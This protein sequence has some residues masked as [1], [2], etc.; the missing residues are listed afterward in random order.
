MA[1]R[2]S[3]AGDDF[4]RLQVVSG[5]DPGQLRVVLAFQVLRY[6]EVPGAPGLPAEPAQGDIADQ[7]LEE[8]ILASLHRP[9]VPYRLDQLSPAQRMQMHFDFGGVMSGENGQTGDVEGLAEHGGI[10]DECPFFST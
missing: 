10:L 4:Q 7:T 2:A 6:G 8:S 1:S 5:D 3:P 9:R